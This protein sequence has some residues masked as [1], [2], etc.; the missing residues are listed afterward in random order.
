M[1]TSKE[2]I[3]RP[4]TLFDLEER[5]KALIFLLNIDINAGG[6]TYECAIRHAVD[7]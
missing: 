3:M 5:M 1:N 2:A 7:I 6:I 4:D